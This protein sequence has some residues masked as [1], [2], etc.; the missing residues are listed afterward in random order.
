MNITKP[1]FFKLLA[2]GTGNCDCH[3]FEVV[4]KN[5]GYDYQFS[6]LRCGKIIEQRSYH[7][8]SNPLIL[9]RMNMDELD[10]KSIII[11][12]KDDFEVMVDV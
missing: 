11:K 5:E 6:C 8:K 2:R 4:T 3:N 1:I 12:H 9:D 10:K 7:I